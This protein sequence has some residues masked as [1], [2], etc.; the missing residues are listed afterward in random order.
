MQLLFLKHTALWRLR[1]DQGVLLKRAYMGPGYETPIRTLP[2]RTIA[3]SFLTLGHDIYIVYG[4][5]VWTARQDNY[6]HN[7]LTYEPH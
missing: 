2:Y 4:D 1:W 5:G 6:T 7:I 3:N